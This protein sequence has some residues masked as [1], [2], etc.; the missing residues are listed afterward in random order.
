MHPYHNKIFR[1]E[2]P[3]ILQFLSNLTLRQCIRYVEERV[4]ALALEL[5]EEEKVF[6]QKQYAKDHV[7]SLKKTLILFL[8]NF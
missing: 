3:N 5:F 8:D 2:N 1:R 4:Q 7:A 6:T